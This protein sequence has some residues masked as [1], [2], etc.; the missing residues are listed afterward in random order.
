MKAKAKSVVLTVEKT[1]VVKMFSRYFQEVWSRD[2]EGLK[3]RVFDDVY[4]AG[5]QRQVLAYEGA[6]ITGRGGLTGKKRRLGSFGA[7]R[8][9]PIGPNPR[10]HPPLP[11]GTRSCSDVIDLLTV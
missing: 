5:L 9:I 4:V 11:P 2:A 1:P 6:L 3:L 7:K 10:D 8:S